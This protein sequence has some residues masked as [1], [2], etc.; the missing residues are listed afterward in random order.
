[1][2]YVLWKGKLVQDVQR[3]L[4]SGDDIRNIDGWL[5]VIYKSCS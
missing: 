5:Q 4:K 1:M 3:K 2:F